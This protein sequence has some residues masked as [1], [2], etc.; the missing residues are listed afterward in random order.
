MAASWRGAGLGRLHCSWRSRTFSGPR[1]R[2]LLEKASAPRILAPPV[3]APGRRMSGWLRFA[4]GVTATGQRDWARK[5]RTT[6]SDCARESNSGP[7]S[8]SA[9]RCRLL[10][11]LGIALHGESHRCGKP[12]RLA[13]S[14]RSP[15]RMRPS[16][17]QM[18]AFEGVRRRFAPH[19]RRARTSP[20]GRRILEI[21]DR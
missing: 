5:D 10:G 18:S 13:R 19:N 21:R 6:K 9:R 16:S 4:Y 2:S 1:S 12:D 11:N 20:D 7:S 14:A 3:V 15:K 8:R 17:C